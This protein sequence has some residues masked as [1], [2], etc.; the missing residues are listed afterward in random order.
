MS[1]EKQRWI[2][3]RARYR[4]RFSMALFLLGL[5]MALYV[6]GTLLSSLFFNWGGEDGRLYR[7]QRTAALL[8]EFSFPGVTMPVIHRPWPLFFSSAGWGDGGLKIKPYFVAQGDY[9]LKKRV[10]KKDVTVGRL[11]INQLLTSTGTRWVWDNGSFEN[12]LYFYHP[13]QLTGW[14][15]QGSRYILQNQSAPTWE[16][17]EMLPEG[18]VAELALSFTQVYSIE[19]VMKMLENYDL[20]I[21]WFAVSTGLEADSSAKGDRQTPLMSF[22]G[23]WGMAEMSSLMLS[24]HSPISDNDSRIREEFFLQSM[25]YLVKNEKLAKK[26]YRGPSDELRLTDRYQYLKEHGVQVYGVVVTGPT[27]ELLQLKQLETV[28][29][30]ALGEVQL[31][32]WFQRNVSGHLY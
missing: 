6:G 18:T 27:K 10:G 28:H 17:L 5:F 30:P 20:D 23:V 1:E 25:E 29:S 22:Q 31:W 16:A 19:Q 7:T 14:G 32:N 3:R 8:T 26:I 4:N 21:T 15:E 12:N 2:L 9:P 11:E 13:A 24:H